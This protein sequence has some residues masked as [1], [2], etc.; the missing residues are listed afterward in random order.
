MSDL[1]LPVTVLMSC[2][3][4]QKWIGNAIESVLNQTFKDFEFI[5]IDD[6]STDSSVNII[7]NYLDKDQRVRL[8]EK[9]NTGLPDSLNV[10]VNNARGKWIARLDADD[11]CESQ[12]LEKQ[13]KVANSDDSL[14]LIGSAYFQMNELGEVDELQ[15]YPESH[16]QLRKNLLHN[17]RF[18]AHSSSLYKTEEVRNVGGYRPRIKKAE[19]Y[20]LWL[21]LSKV[22]KMRC[23]SEPLIRFR[24]HPNQISHEDSGKRQII[25]GRVALTSY[26]IRQFGYPDP[27]NLSE[28]EFQQFRSWIKQKILDNELFEY[29]SFINEIKTQVKNRDYSRFFKYCMKSP[30][31][32][33]RYVGFL[34]RGEALSKKLA[35][36]W[37]Q[38]RHQ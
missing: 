38:K 13:L 21:R 28:S 35:K 3:N 2:Y 26:W 4:G 10:G 22:G 25:D 14:V 31:Y 9:E 12:R 17:K 34:A 29:R 6:G 36:E 15:T 20:D 23:L 27:V 8:I 16:K 7:K 1:S 5:I 24:C 11:L 37:V 33:I 18:F 32:I 30:A 19:D